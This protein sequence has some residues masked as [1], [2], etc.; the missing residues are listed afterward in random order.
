MT[1]KLFPALTDVVPARATQR[2]VSPVKED[3]N[4][5]RRLGS[6]I[7]RSCEVEVKAIF[8]RALGRGRGRRLVLDAVWRLQRSID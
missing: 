1:N 7:G 5:K 3:K 2:Q 6:S 8:G 4:R